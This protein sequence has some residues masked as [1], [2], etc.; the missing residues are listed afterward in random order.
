M[1]IREQLLNSIQEIKEKK[2]GTTIPITKKELIFESSNSSVNNKIWHVL[3]NDIK[4]KKT[5]EFLVSYKCLSCS[6]I[7]QVSTTQFLR[8]MRQC[9]TKCFH[10]NLT[11]HN[12]L[13][14]N[15]TSNLCKPILPLKKVSYEEFYQNS[16]T[17][18]HLYPEQYRNNYM[19]SHLS[20]EDYNRIKKNIISFE[21]GKYTN[22]KDYEYFEIYKVNNQMKFSS[23]LYDKIND[24]IF[25]DNQ[26]IIKCD[27]CEKQWRAKSLKTFKNSYKILCHD[28]KLCNRTF[29]IRAL[30]NLNNDI[31]LYQS[32]LELKFITWCHSLN[33]VVVNG[34]YVEYSFHDKIRK[35]RV[36]F[37]IKDILIEIKDFHIW[38]KNQ[39]ES[40]QWSQKINAVENYVKENG[41]KKYFFITPNNWNQMLSELKCK[42]NK[43]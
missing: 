28:C 42:L 8:K 36:D 12:Y 27:N 4:M 7:I 37:Q 43:I 10:C 35:Y 15:D 33:I 41:L 1:S 11:E 18:F 9:K 5:S 38:H 29:K 17:E 26:P 40:G 32:K 25:K 19:L 22:I 3:I 16:I 13:R 20:K 21:N 31:I 24:K 39:V 14:W 23:V 30:K 6:Q 2:L 34:P